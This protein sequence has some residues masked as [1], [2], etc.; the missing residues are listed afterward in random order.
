MRVALGGK[1]FC[2]TTHVKIVQAGLVI[3]ESG[4]GQAE[5]DVAARFDQFHFG[6][7]LAGAHIF[8]D[9]F[10]HALMTFRSVGQHEHVALLPV[11][12][13]QTAGA[14]RL[15]V[16]MRRDDEQPLFRSDLQ[17]FGN[18]RIFQPWR[19]MT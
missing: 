19:R 7:E 13:E 2:I 9:V 6:E 16:R 3:P 11:Q 10:G 17:L 18:K 14:E 12:R 8:F 5:H 15:I 4:I 1:D